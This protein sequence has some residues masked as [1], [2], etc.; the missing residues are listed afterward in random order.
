MTPVP[1]FAWIKVIV[2]KAAVRLATLKAGS[3][4]DLWLKL[5]GVASGEVHLVLTL[6]EGKGYMD[7]DDI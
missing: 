1:L 7:D 6:K 5:E 4:T 3:E 2:G